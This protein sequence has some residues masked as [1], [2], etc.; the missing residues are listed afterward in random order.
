MAGHSVRSAVEVR[1][2]WPSTV[3]AEVVATPQAAQVCALAPPPSSRARSPVNRTQ[4]AENRVAGTRSSHGPPSY[5]AA[6]AWESSGVNGG[7][8]TYPQAGCSIEK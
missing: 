2:T 6:I 5:T 1:N 8:S 3:T 4:P 7:W